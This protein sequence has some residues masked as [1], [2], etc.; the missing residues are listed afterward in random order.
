MREECVLLGLVEPV[1]LID[2]E[3]RLC[4]PHFES[5]R[6]LCCYL[7]YPRDPLGHRAEGHEYPLGRLRDHMSEGRL[8]RPRWS[9]DD[10]GS[11][12]VLLDRGPERTARSKDIALADYFIKGSRPHTCRQWLPLPYT[13]EE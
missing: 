2:E 7:P 8:P 12:C 11:G 4:A 3:D 9:P 13:G 1:Y 10:E 6:R 5:A